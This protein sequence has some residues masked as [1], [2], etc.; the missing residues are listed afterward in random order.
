MGVWGA[1]NFQQD[2]ALDFLWREV[3]LPLV[4]QIEKV[5][6]DP[7]CA[8]A[9]DPDSGP[10][11][12]A[13]EVLAVLAEQVNAVPPKPEEVTQWRDVFLPAW[14]RTSDDVYFRIEDVAARRQVILATFERLQALATKWHK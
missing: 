11:M 2:N 7:A 6:P 14:D 5:L 9:D 8:Q 10:I 1:G 13:V 4:R 12:A 3:Q